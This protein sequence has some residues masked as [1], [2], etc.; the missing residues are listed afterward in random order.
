MNSQ[1]CDSSQYDY[2]VVGAGA[3]GCVMASRLSEDPWVRVLLLEAGPSRG[4]WEVD[5]PMAAQS[6]RQSRRYVWADTAENT[7]SP[8]LPVRGRMLGGSTSVNNMVYG[9]GHAL[10]YER[11]VS[12]YGCTG[13]GYADV[14]PY[15]K[16][17]ETCID[18]EEGYRGRSGPLHVTRP[19]V[20]ANP[21]N[22]AFLLAG[23]QAGYALTKDASGFRQEGFGPNERTVHEGIR[24][25]SCRAYLSEEVKNR[26]NLI[27]A[28][29][30]LVERIIISD[31]RARGVVYRDDLGTVQAL[32]GREVVLC[33]GAINTAQLLQVSGVGPRDVLERVAVPVLRD[34]PGVGMHLQDHPLVVLKFQTRNLDGFDEHM[35][36]SLKEMAELSWFMGGKGAAA[37]NQCEVAAHLRS[38]AGL[39]YPDVKLE[40]VPHTAWEDAMDDTG[41]RGFHIVVTLM[42]ASSRGTLAIRSANTQEPP[43]LCFNYLSEKSDLIALRE[44]VKLVRELLGQQAF[45]DFSVEELL[46]ASAG[47]DD[48]SLGRWIRANL[49]SANHLSST[50]RMGGAEDPFAV[51]TPDL[52]VKGIAGLRVADASVMP[53]LVAAS[54]T[55]PTIMIAERAADLIRGV[56]EAPH[57]LPYYVS[58]CWATAQR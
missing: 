39:K 10:D 30:V 44:A 35:R 45:E 36:R 11:W 48:D 57:S 27:I 58:S 2:I 13:W 23:Q 15:F 54:T 16:K 3:G 14:L 29:G 42:R 34:L 32:A 49:A 53:V 5:M 7:R 47:A 19:D 21:L 26:S 20:T 17:S 40:L 51:V 4:C 38:R 31:A 1:R 25:S 6:L 52:R 28:T 33:A 46:P 37:S 18:G 55:A 50:C 9:R 43:E 12:L 41:A 56:R 24:W 8:S 22:K